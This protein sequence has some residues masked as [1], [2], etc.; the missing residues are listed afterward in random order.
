MMQK[1]KIVQGILT[2][3]EMMQEKLFDF[4]TTWAKGIAI[5]KHEM[6]E[7]PANGKLSLDTLSHKMAYDAN[8]T[9]NTMVYKPL[10]FEESM[11]MMT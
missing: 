2:R 11:E 8:K 10:G 6:K 9:Y 1:Y 5:V 3:R 7:L 4:A